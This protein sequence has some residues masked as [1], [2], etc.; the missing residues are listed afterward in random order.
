[1][2]ELN[3]LKALTLHIRAGTSD[4]QHSLSRSLEVV[5]ILIP[6]MV[7]VPGRG[8]GVYRFFSVLMAR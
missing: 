4:V 5:R 2:Q 3:A 6:T 7:G 8:K 1:M